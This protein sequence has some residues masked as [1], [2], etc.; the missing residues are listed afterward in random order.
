MIYQKLICIDKNYDSLTFNKVYIGKR[1]NINNRFFG[2][3]DNEK[4]IGLFPCSIFKSVDELR[5]DR[6]KNILGG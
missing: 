4:P 2:I 6:L 1:P 5:N 3:F